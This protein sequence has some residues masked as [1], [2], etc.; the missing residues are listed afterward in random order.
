MTGARLVELYEARRPGETAPAEKM[1]EMQADS[2]VDGVHDATEGKGWC[3]SSKFRPK[4]I[5]IQEHVIWD[6]RALPAEQLKRNAAELI[7]ELLRRRYP[8]GERS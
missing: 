8:C 5:T 3:Y 1:R 2:Y 7:V 6:L 4:P